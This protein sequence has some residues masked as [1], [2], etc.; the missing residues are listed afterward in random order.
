MRS[1]V[2]NFIDLNRKVYTL[3]IPYGR[4]KLV[5]IFALTLINGI[6]GVIGV[7]SIFPFLALASDPSRLQNSR[8]GKA[9]LQFLPPMSDAQLLIVAGV[10]SIV[11]LLATNAIT[12]IAECVRVRYAH[13]FGHWLR[14]RLL[15]KITSRPYIVFLNTNSNIFVK[16]VFTDVGMFTNAI[17]LP[18]LESKSRFINV[19]FLIGLIYVVHPEISLFI[20]FG[21]GGY[22]F[23]IYWFLNAQRKRIDHQIWDSY[24]KF[25]IEC[26]QMITGI[27]PIK[28]HAKEETFI[29]RFEKESLRHAKANPWLT[30]YGASP[31]YLIESIAFAAIILVVLFNA[32]Q[33]Q[34]LSAILPN[35]GVIA[36]AGYR[37]LPS[38]QMIYAQMT[39]IE[40][41]RTSLEEVYTEF[42]AAETES[43]HTPQPPPQRMPWKNSIR[44]LNLTFQY[45]NSKRPAVKNLTVTIPKNASIGIVG[46]T[47]CGKSTLVELILGLLTP[48]SGQILIDDIPLTTANARNWRAGIGYVPQDIFL[49]D[50]TVTAN[51]AFGIPE[52]E[53]DHDRLREAAAAAQ[54]LQFIENELPQGF[55][56]IVGERGVRLS[57]GQRQRIGLARALYHKPDLLILDEA[58]SALDIHTEAEVMKTINALHGSMTMIIIAH[59]LNT[60]ANCD[61]KIQ[62]DSLTPPYATADL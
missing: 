49:T 1:I 50:D 28:V 45:P 52:T 30:F 26:Q 57:G 34:E 19:L 12:L 54:I 60:V 61:Q 22:Y 25:F 53:I 14:L 48:S 8:I 43:I 2:R 44:L 15:R 35:L 56:T 3:A 23:L 13:N 17:L 59:R 4:A 20:A 16:K 5:W 29:K 37:V 24:R 46:A 38:I 39:Q 9:F 31:R 47:G 27:K 58:T 21:L 10:F 55:Q 18:L 40:G 51:I 36:F 7:T 33:G 6:F 11:M 42:L 32:G 62:L 41:N